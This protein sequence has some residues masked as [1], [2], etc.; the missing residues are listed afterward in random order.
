MILILEFQHRIWIWHLHLLALTDKTQSVWRFSN[1]TKFT[2][3]TNKFHGSHPVWLLGVRLGG[4]RTWIEKTSIYLTIWCTTTS[5]TVIS[6]RFIWFNRIM[7]HKIT[8]CIIFIT[9]GSITTDWASIMIKISFAASWMKAT[10]I[11]N[12]IDPNVWSCI[13][14]ATTMINIATTWLLKNKSNRRNGIFV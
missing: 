4:S 11:Q 7:T 12:W 3:S 1:V 5:C 10:N 6:S 9:T 14:R 2:N 13:V 8:S